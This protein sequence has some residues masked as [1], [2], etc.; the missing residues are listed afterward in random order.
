FV[1][2]DKL[3]SLHATGGCRSMHGFNSIGSYPATFALPHSRPQISLAPGWVD[4]RVACLVIWTP[5]SKTDARFQEN[6]SSE[7]IFWSEVRRM[8]RSSR[9][10]RTHESIN[11]IPGNPSKVFL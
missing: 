4:A 5:K 3:S 8:P 6:C 9:H 2:Y 7:I 11:D 1:A 10:N